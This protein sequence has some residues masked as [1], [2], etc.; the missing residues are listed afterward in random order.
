MQ[1][2][3]YYFIT[4]IVKLFK[5]FEQPLLCNCVMKPNEIL[6]KDIAISIYKLQQNMCKLSNEGF[7]LS[8]FCI[9]LF[10]CAC[11]SGNKS[12]Y[13]CLVGEMDMFVVRKK[14]RPWY[15]KF[16]GMLHL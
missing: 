9:N 2:R 16:T 12:D 13:S 1:S 8:P 4:N 11:H 15:F 3:E 5:L 7:V 10:T 6:V 14:Q